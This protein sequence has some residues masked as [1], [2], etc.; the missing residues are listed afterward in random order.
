[1][2]DLLVRMTPGREWYG[3]RVD[4]LPPY[5]PAVVD[6]FIRRFALRYVV[7]APD[8]ADVLG[9]VEDL[10]GNRVVRRRVIGDYVLLE[11]AAP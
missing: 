7:A 1:M 10:F 11:L 6:A 8:Y 9:E 5:E 3:R 4:R 2:G